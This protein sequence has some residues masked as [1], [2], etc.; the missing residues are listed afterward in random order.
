MGSAKRAFNAMVWSAIVNIVTAIYGF[1]AA[2]LLIRYFGRSEYGLI[3]L[4]TSV[5]AYMQLMDMGL[6]STNVRFFSNWIAK[7]DTGKVKKLMQTCTAFYGVI[8]LI[9]AAVLIIVSLFSS[10]IFNVSPEQD[11]VLKEMLWALSIVAIINWY[12][13]CYGQLISATENV[14]WVQKRTLVT[15]LL[16]VV[17]VIATLTLKLTI[18]QY[19]LLSL[20]AGLIVLPATIRKVKRETPFIS[21]R[22]KFDKKTFKEILPYSLNIFSFGIFQFSYNNLRPVI[23]G[24]RGTIESVTDHGVI[25]SIA[26]LVSMVGGIFIGALLPASS[27]IVAKGDQEN[28]NRLAYRGTHYLTMILCFCAFGLMAVDKDLMMVYV[29]KDFMHLIPWLNIW[30]FLTITGNVSCISSLILAG[31]KLRPLTFSSAIASISALVV[32]WF[33]VPYYQAG[34]AV[35]AMIAYNAVQQLFYYAYLWPRML[36]INSWRILI[37]TDVPFIVLGVLFV[38][39]LNYMPHLDNHWINIFLFGGAFAILYIAACCLILKKEDREYIF[40]LIKKK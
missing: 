35:I 10:Q 22:A 13:S 30:L 33:A 5:N 34:G 18:F 20:V 12:T 25:A 21:L 1:I 23:L 24:M 17:V 2:P 40:S 36:K 39:L 3:A 6:S 11:I 16:M 14:A 19:F 29:G 9:N 37:K 26:A 38:L 31:T 15:K 28:F 27:R 7:G 32:C 4:A 8:G